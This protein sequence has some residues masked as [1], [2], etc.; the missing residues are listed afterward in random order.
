MYLYV[1]IYTSKAPSTHK[2]RRKVHYGAQRNRDHH[3]MKCRIPY[4]CVCVYV[5]VCVCMCVCVRTCVR[6]Y[7]CVCVCLYK[8]HHGAQ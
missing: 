5:R 4:T 1:H 8:V 3:Q 2:Q 7:A 6:A